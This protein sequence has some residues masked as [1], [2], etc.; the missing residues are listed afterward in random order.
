MTQ[1]QNIKEL[2][3]IQQI[4]V[5]VCSNCNLPTKHGHWHMVHCLVA[6]KHALPIERKARFDF[7]YGLVW[8]G[9]NRVNHLVAVLQFQFYRLDTAIVSCNPDEAYKAGKELA[10]AGRELLGEAALQ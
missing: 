9:F 3:P 1:M 2:E 8:K 7:V 10:R 4:E 6:L 5:A